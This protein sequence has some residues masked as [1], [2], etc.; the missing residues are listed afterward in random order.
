[1][2]IGIIIIYNNKLQQQLK[3]HSSIL[4]VDFHCVDCEAGFQGSVNVEDM[5]Q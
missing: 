4:T 2:M 1:M 5:R 3:I